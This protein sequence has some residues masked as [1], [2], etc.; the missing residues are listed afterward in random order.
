MC[1]NVGIK[2]DGLDLRDFR[3]LMGLMGYFGTHGIFWNYG[4]DGDSWDM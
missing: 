4:I 1:E 3:E 2:G